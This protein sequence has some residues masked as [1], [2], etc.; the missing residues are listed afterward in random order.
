MKNRLDNPLTSPSDNSPENMKYSLVPIDPSK[1][2]D[3]RQE[4]LMRQCL[5]MMT[6][7]PPILSRLTV[8]NIEV[9]EYLHN[10]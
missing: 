6:P 7:P 2:V 8:P 3:R 5:V 4:N 10:K 9:N 1:P